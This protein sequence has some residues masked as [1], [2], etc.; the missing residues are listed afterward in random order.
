MKTSPRLP[1][2]L[3]AAALLCDGGTA[4][5][6]SRP[7]SG[8][9]GRTVQVPDHITRMVG[10]GGAVDEWVLLLG[11]PEKLVATSANVKKNAWYAKIYP[12]ILTVPTAFSSGDINIEALIGQNPQVAILLAGMP[13]I[14]K[15]ERA[16]IPT[17]V[18]ERRDPDELMRAIDIAA[19]ILGPK[20]EQVA[21]RFRTYYQ[22]NIKLVTERTAPLPAAQR[23]RVYYASGSPLTTEGKDSLVTSWIDMAGGRNMAAGAEIE[24]MGRKVSMEDVVAWNPEVIITMNP[25]ARDEILRNDQ[26]KEVAAVRTKRVY[27]NPKSVY[28]WSVRSADE[29]IQVLWAA[30]TIHPELFGDIEMI[31]ETKRFH[32]EFYSY[33]LTDSDAQKILDAE[34]PE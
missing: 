22:A 30:K 15:I 2:W 14:D 9:D 8:M 12:G 4:W 26:W 32:K 16:G 11:S 13:V 6:D 34:P 19:R 24:G 23:T 27:V 1:A 21:A 18:L 33:D 28:S 10:T 31:I 29:A 20:E 25:G 3:L 17:V 7:I 5:A